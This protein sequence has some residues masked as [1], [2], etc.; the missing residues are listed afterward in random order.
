[1]Q[2][3]ALKTQLLG[4]AMR[5]WRH[6]FHRFPE[7]GFD[8]HRTAARIAELLDGFGL[9][10]SRGI[11]QTGVV[12]V[13]RRGTSA[14]SIALRADMD[15]LPIQESNA[16]KHRSES[17]G[18]M[19]ACGHDGYISMLLG[20]ARYLAQQGD[21]DGQVVFIFQPN[22][23]H[24]FGAQ[25]MIEDGLFEANAIDEIYGMHNLPGLPLGTFASRPGPI[26]ASESLFEI[27]VRARGGHAALPHMGV[28]AITVAAE[29]VGGL[30][31]IVSRKLD[32]GQNGVVS[33]TEFITDGRRNVLPGQAV[34]KGDA[35]ALTPQAT[36]LIEKQMRQIVHG[37]CLAHDITAEV[38]FET[39]FPPTLNDAE[40]TADAM[41][42]AS[43]VVGPTA[44]NSASSPKLFSEDFAHFAAARPGCF[45][46]IGNGTEGAYAR[47]LHSADYD[48]ND[49][50]LQVGS[51]FWVTLVEQQLGKGA[52]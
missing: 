26:T 20:A 24:G 3:P 30:Q 38:Q 40:K 43:A 37:I 11:G 19:H 2:K 6:D 16:F 14:K 48:F 25:A 50:A 18:K 13:L 17:A 1:M 5:A 21:F 12:G 35:R 10:V 39:F 52:V 32:P 28:D 36:A 9:S 34:L 51:T 29:I 15:A 8:E 7:L 42:A 31:T 41:R 4:D 47:P 27:T 23:E 46:L 22:E 44:V 33:V 45:V 49:A